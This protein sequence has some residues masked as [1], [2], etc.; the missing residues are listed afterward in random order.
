[1][2]GTCVDRANRFVERPDVREAASRA[3]NARFW[4][5]GTGMGEWSAATRSRPDGAC[6]VQAGRELEAC[7][8]A[9]PI[10]AAGASEALASPAQAA[11]NHARTGTPVP[12]PVARIFL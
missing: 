11:V 7:A 9:P 6:P 5:R 2:G 4:R 8:P 10:G 1:M 12:K 3:P